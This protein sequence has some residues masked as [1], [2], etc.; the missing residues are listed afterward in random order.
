M[1]APHYPPFNLVMGLFCGGKWGFCR[2]FVMLT[3]WMAMGI[4]YAWCMESTLR[5]KP[6]TGIKI[7]AMLNSKD[8]VIRSWTQ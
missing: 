1:T 3:R 7:G 8:A 6:R 4:I 2:L 5:V